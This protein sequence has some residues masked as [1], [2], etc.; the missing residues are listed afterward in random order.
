MTAEVAG[1]LPVPVVLTWRE[2]AGLP[3][4]RATDI[5]RGKWR[6][7]QMTAAVPLGL[8]ADR[9][10]TSTEVN[11]VLAHAEALRQR[12]A[13]EYNDPPEVIR[14]RRRELQTELGPKTASPRRAIA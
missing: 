6:T 8:E 12:W 1:R 5:V 4:S 2:I 7:A 10:L 9:P 11:L 13:A 3:R 14:R